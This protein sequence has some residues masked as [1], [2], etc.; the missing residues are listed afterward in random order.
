[1]TTLTPRR[2][3]GSRLIEDSDGIRIVDSFRATEISG[4]DHASR[5]YNVRRHSDLPVQGQSHPSVPGIQVVSTEVEFLNTE[6]TIADVFVTWGRPA[7]GLTG[8]AASETGPGAVEFAAE[9][10]QEET[11]RDIFGNPLVTEY[12]GTFNPDPEENSL[13]EGDVASSILRLFRRTHSVEFDRSLWTVRLRRRE[14]R[15]PKEAAEKFH[16]AVNSR[17]WSGFPE[18]TW[19]C[20]GI[21]ST[22][23]GD[24]THDVGYFFSYKKE[25][26]LVELKAK[27]GGF[28]PNDAG[29]ANGFSRRHIYELED[30]NELGVGF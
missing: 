14:T 29:A 7:S 22:D 24:G 27:V 8:D 16:N 25:T 1:M 19:R 18:H 2:G 3:D 11:S 4:G 5:L 6:G 21:T 30:F 17:P 28:I 20:R 15:V 9:T 23:N 10:I 26:W 13:E 12:V